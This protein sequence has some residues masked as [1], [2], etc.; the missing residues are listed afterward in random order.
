MRKPSYHYFSRCENFLHV[1]R[2]NYVVTP[3]TSIV[4]DMIQQSSLLTVCNPPPLYLKISI[5]T[6]NCKLGI[7]GIRL[8]N[9]NLRKSGLL[10]FQ[11]DQIYNFMF[12]KKNLLQIHNIQGCFKIWLKLSSLDTLVL[13]FHGF[14]IFS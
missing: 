11:L 4:R 14:E 2:E 1:E 10:Q 7:F 9:D 6:P 13:I 8:W 12:S 3:L 5:D